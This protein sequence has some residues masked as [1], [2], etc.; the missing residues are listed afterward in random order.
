MATPPNP[1]GGADADAA[2]AAPP[3]NPGGAGPDAASAAPPPHPAPIGSRLR[4]ALS[5][6]T[7]ILYDF[8]DTIFSASILTFFF[9]LWVTDDMGGSDAVFAFALAGSALIVALTSPMFG[10]LSDTLNR[11]V[12][13]LAVSVLLC[14]ACTGMIGMFGGLSAGVALFFL[15]NFLYQT[16]LIFYNSL[17]LNVSSESSR[18]IVSGIGVGAGYIGLFV[19]FMLLGP[20]VE[21]NGNQCEFLPIERGNQCAFLPTALMYVLFAAPLLLIVR[22]VG[23]RHRIDW[24]LL[25]DSYAQLYA[26]FRN[27]RLHKNLFRF[28]IGRFLYMEAINT[29][30]SFYV[31]Y[32]VAVSD[33][34]TSDSARDM[35]VRVIMVAVVSSIVAGFLTS[36]F[37]AKRVLTVALAGWAFVVVAASLATDLWM[38]W[39][40]AVLTGMCWGAPQIADRVMLTKLAPPSQIGE[41]FGL[42][43]MSGRLS[44][45][46]GPALWGL[47]T[48]ALMSLDEWRYRIAM[49]II[50]LFLIAGLYLLLGVRE[51]REPPDEPV[52]GGAA[53]GGAASGGMDDMDALPGPSGNAA[54]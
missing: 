19:A 54:R 17:I 14:A 53:D 23:Q 52:G 39:A 20:Q 12:P 37:G 43:Q 29:V 45:V 26:T 8:S 34:F 16:G 1:S 50:A 46:L 44:A 5:T 4:R 10:A 3:P 9:P 32:L 2:S 25:G 7:W 18:G 36:R 33:D 51:K 6:P 11:R 13:L 42:F 49:L 41:F 31:I 27:A 15:A 30:S 48:T 47:T 28:I 35:V 38:F 24:R 40:I 21:A 22:D